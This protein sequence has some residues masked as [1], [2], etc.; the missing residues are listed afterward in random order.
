[1]LI[2]IN[3]IMIENLTTY[4]VKFCLSYNRVHILNLKKYLP[5]AVVTAHRA[6]K[7]SYGQNHTHKTITVKQL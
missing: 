1:M 3:V 4:L 2:S 6:F 7:F 5:V